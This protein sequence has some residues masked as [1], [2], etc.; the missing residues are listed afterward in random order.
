MPSSSLPPSLSLSLS[1]SLSTTL[2]MHAGDLHTQNPLDLCHMYIA[3]SQPERERDRDR[4]RGREI[5]RG[6]D[7]ERGFG[8]DHISHVTGHARAL[9]KPH[10]YKQTQMQT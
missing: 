9:S 5:E 10:T 2:F 4:E 6:R 7:R 1:L 3:A 8:R